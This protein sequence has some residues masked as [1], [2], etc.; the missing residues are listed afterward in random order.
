M[1]KIK[2]IE[3][4]AQSNT[5]WASTAF[6]SPR[7][8]LTAPTKSSA[9]PNTSQGPRIDSPPASS[10]RTLAKSCFDRTSK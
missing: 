10:A 2:H 3:S 9:L 1:S 5:L 7:S 8:W 6:T 4:M